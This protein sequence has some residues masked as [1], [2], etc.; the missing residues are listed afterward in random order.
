MNHTISQKINFEKGV[1]LKGFKDA[2]HN[3]KHNEHDS[4]TN[5]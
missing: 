3:I 1:P 4:S 2:Q 5:D